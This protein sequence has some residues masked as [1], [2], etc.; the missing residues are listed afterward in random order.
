L[1]DPRAEPRPLHYHDLG[2]LAS[3]S[4][5]YA[6]AELGPIRATGPI[7]WVLWLF[8]HLAFLTG[9]KNRVTTVFHWAVSFIGRG[10]AERTITMKQFLA[11]RVIPA[12]AAEPAREPIRQTPPRP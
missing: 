12:R 5:S 3:I 10:R 9:F 1:R 8:V 11:R 2:T 7:A 4:R 6:I